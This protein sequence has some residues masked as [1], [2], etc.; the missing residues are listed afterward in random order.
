MITEKSPKIS[1][2]FYCEF[3]DY[4][5][6]KQSEYN[7]HTLTSKHKNNDGQLHKNLQNLQKY[8]CE[9][10]AVVL[11]YCKKQHL[12]SKKHNNYLRAK[13]SLI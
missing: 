8:T 7:K 10:E 5:C 2:K 13:M 9:C 11:L 4:K 12:K 6:S 1:S 3:C